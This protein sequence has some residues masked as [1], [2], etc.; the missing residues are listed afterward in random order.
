[1]A[2]SRTEQQLDAVSLSH[3][4]HSDERAQ[5]VAS[6]RCQLTEHLDKLNL[7]AHRSGN[8]TKEQI[9]LSHSVHRLDFLARE[10]KAL[11]RRALTLV[12]R[13]AVGT[14]IEPERISPKI[15][16][17]GPDSTESLLFRL[18]TTSW[19]VP[20]STGYGRRMRF[21]IIDRNNE[22]L[23]GVLAIGDPVFNLRARDNWIQWTVEDRRERLVNVMDAYVVGAVPPYSHL[24]GGKLV[25][26]L[27]GSSEVALGFKQRYAQST[28]VISEKPKNPRLALVTI[29]SALGRSSIYNRVKLPGLLDL[30]FIGTTQGWGHFHIPDTIFSNMRL[31]LSLD[32]H[33]YADGHQFGSGP[34]WRMRVIR[35]ALS[36]IGLD[37]ALLRHGIGREIYAMPLAQ[38]WCAFLRGKARIYGSQRPSVDTISKACLER[39]VVPRSMRKSDYLA[40]SSEDR[41]HLLAP[42]FGDGVGVVG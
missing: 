20:V 6:L 22:K 9:R 3:D 24:L 17:V 42:I 1:M 8:S 29:T 5:L 35:K 26:A 25:T 27:I 37:E 12:E 36:L 28:G 30:K 7:D 40:W 39:W 23:I 4:C 15:I 16:P 33:K 2:H 38:N 14:D 41:A 31:L 32:G 13:F 21:I 18:A 10:R 11:A 34:N 19:S